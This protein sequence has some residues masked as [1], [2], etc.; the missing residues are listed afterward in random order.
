MD[1]TNWRGKQVIISNY[2]QAASN[3]AVSTAHYL[4]CCSNDCE[5]L[6]DEIEMAFGTPSAPPRKLFS[7]VGNVSSQSTL[8]DDFAPGLDASF[9]KQLEQIASVHGGEVPLH[10]RL[11]AQ[12]LHYVFPRECAFPHKAGV[13]A[14]ITPYEYGDD[15]Y[16]TAEEMQRHVNASHVQQAVQKEDLQ[17]M[18][19]WT[20]D[21]ELIAEQSLGL[22]APWE[23]ENYTLPG[24]AMV[25]FL[26][27]LLGLGSARRMSLSSIA[28]LPLSSKGHLV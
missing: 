22:Q 7:V 11:F 18:S 26:A 14:S 19:Q 20:A 23:Q 21:D 13:A 10:G 17:W 1:E 16:A 6:L 8:D 28:G 27:G 24:L 15:F 12:W 3:C 4:V 9:L 2:M 5:A 25:I